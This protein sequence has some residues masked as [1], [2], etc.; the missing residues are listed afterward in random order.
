MLKLFER[1]KAVKG[2]HLNYEIK[3]R[4]EKYKNRNVSN[5]SIK[6]QKRKYF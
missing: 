4:G 6:K 2:M 3:K 5:E 1:I